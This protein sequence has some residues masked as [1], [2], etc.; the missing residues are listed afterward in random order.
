MHQFDANVR[1]CAPDAAP[2]L[3]EFCVLAALNAKAAA[4]AWQPVVLLKFSDAV[5]NAACPAL[6]SS[7]LG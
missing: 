3:L 4:E 6:A 5:G 1:L 7:P 2:P